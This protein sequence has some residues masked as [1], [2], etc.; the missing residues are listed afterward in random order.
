MNQRGMVVE[1][2]DSD[3]KGSWFNSWLSP[4]FVSIPAYSITASD[5]R[6]GAMDD[7]DLTV[8]S[9]QGNA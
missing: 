7:K 2:F 3:A 1:I 9:D 4:K 6:A 5:C 8:S